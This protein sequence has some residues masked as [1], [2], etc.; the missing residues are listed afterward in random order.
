MSMH[1]CYFDPYYYMRNVWIGLHVKA[2]LRART[3]A[4]YDHTIVSARLRCDLDSKRGL[5]PW[6]G[7]ELN[8]E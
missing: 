7:S 4:K 5:Q 6:L 1:E 3:K 8:H 2:T